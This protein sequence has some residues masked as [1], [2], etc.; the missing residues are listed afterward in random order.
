MDKTRGDGIGGERTSSTEGD[1]KAS[2]MN[3]KDD[4]DVRKRFKAERKLTKK[5][6]ER[7][8]KKKKEGGTWL[9][10]VF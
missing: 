5:K 7:L 10:C 8:K 9:F 4:R 6:V 3:E 1:G 2:R